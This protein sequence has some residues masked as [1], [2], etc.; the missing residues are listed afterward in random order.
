MGGTTISNE[1]EK[2][3]N[4]ALQTSSYGVTV[5]KI[6]GTTRVSGNLIWYGNFR[7]IA[8]TT[9]TTSG[10][11]GVGKV[12]T[13]DTSY[14]YTAAVMMA[15]G[16][17]PITGIGAVWRGK[18]KTTLADLG[19]TLFN[20]T[21]GQATWSFLSAYNTPANWLFDSQ[22]GY[23]DHYTNTQAPFT[24]QA[25]GYSSTA[26][27]ASS[28]YDLGTD[29]NVPNHGFEVL[30]S[31]IYGSGIQDADPSAI[32]SDIVT[33]VQYGSGLSGSFVDTLTDYSNYCVSLGLFVSPAYTEQRSAADVIKELT[34]LTN[35]GIVWSGGK[36]KVIPYGDQ[37]STGNGKTYIPNLNPL[38]DLTEDDF[39][40]SE[41]PVKIR[42]T[43]SSDAKNRIAFEFVN[44]QNQY[45]T[46]VV[47]VED[48]DA[49]E[50][51]GLKPADNISA[52]MFCLPAAAKMSAQ[53][54]LQ[55]LLYKRN[56]YEFKVN[57]RY[58]MLEPMDIVTITDLPI[59]LD[60]LPVRL[61][62]VTEIDGGFDIVAEDLNIGVAS[63]ASY[64]HDNGLRWQSTINA[65]PQS[66][67]SPFIFEL[68]PDPTTTGLAIGIATGAQTG[69]LLYGGCR[70]WSSFDGVNYRQVG[71][72]YGNSRF[73][74]TTALY[75][76]ASGVYSDQP[77]KV[78]LAAGG[79]LISGSAT[80]ADNAATLIVVNNEYMAHQ[81]ATL[82]AVNNY[83]LSPVNR[84]L[85]NTTPQLH[86]SGSRWARVDQAIAKLTDLDLSLIGKTIY[87]KLTAF[88]TY[89]A[90][91]QDLSEVSATTYTITGWAKAFETPTDWSDVAGVGRPED[92]A[93]RNVFRG[94]WSSSSIVYVVGDEVR[95]QSSSWSAKVAHVSSS[96]NGP[97]LLPITSNANWELRSQTGEDG[98]LV[99]FVWRRAATQPDT[100]TGNGIPAGWFDDPPAG[101]DP[102]WLS[103]AKQELD[104]S[105]VAGEAWSTPIRH[106]GPA[107]APGAPGATGVSIRKIWQRST[108]QPATPAASDA[109]PAGW[110]D[111]PGAASGSGTLWA[112]TGER[113][114]GAVNFTW[115]TP[116]RDEAITSTNTGQFVVLGFTV[117]GTIS[118]TL[119]PGQSRQIFGQANLSS[120]TGGGSAHVQIESRLNGGAWSASNGP[121]EPY[122]VGEPAVLE[123]S[124]TIT[125]SAL[126]SAN[127][128]V[129]GTVIRSNTSSGSL[130]TSSSQLSI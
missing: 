124:I 81:G 95:N 67:Q 128:Q 84:G 77:L 11:K 26:Y 65:K 22:Y 74:T 79:Q 75:P 108:T 3:A 94:D 4:I 53:L 88:N 24:D 73:G 57:A 106:D 112:T 114:A 64:A 1:Q 8:H 20:G 63:A 41:N 115:T 42:R 37:P 29:A 76:S 62:S 126:V 129:R 109:T 21:A 10:G 66:A 125:N 25:L 111:T 122:A 100:P 118:F 98:K 14:T 69:D 28:A 48:Q 117:S 103:K 80:D 127:Y 119:S 17:G 110:F 35:S 27:L 43:A 32:V 2:I 58:P 85:Y 113:A 55:K 49:I 39:L 54:A 116:V 96:V 70:I 105:L 51:Y 87:I 121:S 15:L 45:N 71:T 92:N 82:T 6:Y 89:D 68:P 90:G 56:E 47:S 5:A 61:V 104:G 52:K 97:P 72:L 40:E 102:L 50:K 60:R 36:I 46:E 120:P 78:Q 93:T 101:S 7:A 91:E 23:Y 83:D 107:G 33:S 30:G 59:G 123:H 18:D 9:K 44:R 34:D 12:T 38:Y 19:L 13:K 99:E 31:H 16:E 86:A 130:V